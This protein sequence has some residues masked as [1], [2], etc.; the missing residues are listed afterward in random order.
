MKPPL[1]AVVGRPNVG[2]S[3]LVNR[4]AASREAIVHAQPGVT[5]DRNYVGTDW[6]GK[7]FL[8]IDTG[9]LDFVT[10]EP[11][12]RQVTRQ[13]ML[14]V[15]E[16]ALIIFVVDGTTGPAGEDQEI[17]KVLRATKKPVLLVVN[18]VD[19]PTREML[20]HDFYGLGVG[21]PRVVS[22]MHGLG[23]GDLLD[24][25]AALL[26]ALPAFLTATEEE[27]REEVVEPET[28]VAI[29]GRPNAGKSSI[30]NRLIGEQRAIVSEMPGTTRDAV[31]TLIQL[32]G[33]S[34]RFVDTAGLKRPPK[35]SED[36][37]YYGFVRALRALDR[38]DIALL[39]VDAGEGVT[40]QDQRVASLALARNCAAIVLLNKWDLVRD[41]ERQREI[42]KQ[43]FD[44]LRFIEYAPV[45]KVSALTGEGIDAL[46]AALEFIAGEYRKRVA[47]PRL[48]AFISHV[49]GEETLPSKRGKALKI[50]YVTQVGTA[51]PTFVF[52][53]ND[54]VLV[55]A[56]FRR[57]MENR[58]R[59]AFGFEGTPLAL[60]FKR[61]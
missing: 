34:Y 16:A 5:R 50:T 4:I 10:S 14:A 56:S 51:P 43:L 32:D 61:K 35:I 3:T 55:T 44:K 19:D 45:L 25:V 26:P 40:N 48:N 20:V 36:V 8:L 30:L 46:D 57:H 6:R 13:A 37:E 21:E 9:G 53:V 29:V 52:F 31:D 22:A 27:T 59:K 11:I 1:V 58:M 15:E 28:G 23:I 18:K 33:R 42:D 2:K 17:A 12:E 47:T 7:S 60:H 41:A 39:I 49:R 38:A 54:P 24:E